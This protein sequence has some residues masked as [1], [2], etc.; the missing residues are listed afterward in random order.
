MIMN[1][2]DIE[3]FI[4][5]MEEIGDVWQEEDVE[6]VYGEYT[7]EEALADRKASVGIFGDIINKVLNR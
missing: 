4:E 2:R 3:E 6:R 7:L 1:K 5:Q